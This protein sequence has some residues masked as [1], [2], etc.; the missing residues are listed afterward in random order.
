MIDTIVLSMPYKKVFTDPV[1]DRIGSKW[2]LQKRTPGYDKYVRNP[3]A[4]DKQGGLYFP[5]VTAYIRKG[6]GSSWKDA[7]STIRIEFSAPKLIYQNNVDELSDNQFE[8]V[9]QTLIDRL[10]VM[11]VLIA[12]HILSAAEVRAVHYSKNIM[13]LRGYTSQYVIS[14]LG[15]INLNKRFDF[16]KTRYLNDGQSMTAH[17]ATHEFIIYDK[18]A[19]LAQGNKRA[20]DRD[21]TS[22]QQ[23]L[24]EEFNKPERQPEILRFEIRLAHKRKLNAFFKQLGFAPDPTFKD[25]FSV[26]KSKTVVK[27]Y[28]ETMVGG[29]AAI[30]FAHSITTKDLL[31]QILLANKTM[32]SKEA[33]YRAS[34]LTMAREGGGMRELRSILGKRGNGRAWSRTVADI[35]SM[36]TRLD[37]LRP[38]DWFDQI[39]QGFEAYEPLKTVD[40]LS[41]QK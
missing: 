2:H 9:V 38:R 17:T 10:K 18:V 33:I 36:A 1:S 28:W 5:R 24:F 29:N 27:H 4:L 40:L 13:L 20:I 19:D 3:S 7:E 22:Q 32:R 37:K 26:E 16:A 31:R 8:K 34:L 39:T 21:Q 35:R 12:P 30:L 11:N 25:V 15:K 41:K 23:G 14:E 6:S